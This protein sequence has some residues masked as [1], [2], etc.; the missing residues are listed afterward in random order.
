MPIQTLAD[1][2]ADRA[3]TAPQDPAIIFHDQPLSY[4]DLNARIERAA[5][6]RAGLGI[7]PGD[8]VAL[9]LPNITEF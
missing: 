3:A 9:L 2:V 4:S 7:A 1:I 6:G 8:R 5:A